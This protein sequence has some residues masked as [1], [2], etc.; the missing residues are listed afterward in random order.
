MPAPKGWS[1]VKLKAA[2]I[3]RLDMLREGPPGDPPLS[4]DSQINL[5]I[6]EHYQKCRV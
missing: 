6:D 1:T 5:L 3:K 4:L 2:T